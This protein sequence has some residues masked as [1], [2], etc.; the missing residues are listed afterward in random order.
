MALITTIPGADF[1]ASGL[2]QISRIVA[3]FSTANLRGLY[4][5]EDGVNGSEISTATDS[6]GL[7][8]HAAL[9]SG[10]GAGVKSAEGLVCTTSTTPA[11]FSAPGLALGQA[12]SAVMVVKTDIEVDGSTSYPWFWRPSSD[13]GAG[14]GATQT[15]GEMI[16]FD[17]T[18]TVSKQNVGWFNSAGYMNGT[19]SGFVRR[20]ISSSGT[21]KTVWA[22]VAFGFSPAANRF[23]LSFAGSNFETV[24][25]TP[26]AASA[27]KVGTHLFGVGRYGGSANNHPGRMALFAIYSGERTVAELAGL[28]TT[29]KA[30]VASRGI[31]AA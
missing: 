2:P 23:R 5:F 16:N 28:I 30:R 26:G 7:G 31:A 21:D 15:T 11:V 1:S 4:L 3:G 8:N 22:A 18:A 29:A 13:I 27:A 9:A 14:L 12:F 6:S 24:H 17:R 10:G 19:G 25:A 20:G